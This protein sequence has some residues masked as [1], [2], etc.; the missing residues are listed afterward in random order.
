MGTACGDRS[1]AIHDAN[2]FDMDT[3]FADVVS[4]QEAIEKIRAG[5]S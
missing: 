5:W 1:S 2:I 3:K 4:E